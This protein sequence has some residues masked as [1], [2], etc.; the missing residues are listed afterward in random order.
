MQQ[1]LGHLQ[2]DVSAADHGY[3]GDVAQAENLVQEQAVLHRLEVED[4][5]RIRAGDFGV[6]AVAAGRN[7][8]HVI[9]VFKD[10]ARIQISNCYGLPFGINPR[11]L[12]EQMRLD[13][14]LF[15][16]GLRPGDQFRGIVIEAAHIIRKAACAVGEEAAA[17][18]HHNLCVRLDAPELGGGGHS[19]RH[20]ADDDG[21]HIACTSISRF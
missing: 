5:G 1:R 19:G 17:L 7:H 8:E 10:G 18:I 21:F 12:V 14:H 15:V 3:A 6:N 11:D 13:A 4:G 20:A 9:S 16:D 2:P